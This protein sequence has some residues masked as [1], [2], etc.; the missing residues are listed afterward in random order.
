[1]CVVGR[2]ETTAERWQGRADV[3]ELECQ[4]GIVMIGRADCRFIYVEDVAEDPD[5][6][7][8]A[9]IALGDVLTVRKGRFDCGVRG[10]PLPCKKCFD[11]R[12]RIRYRRRAKPG[13]PM[14]ILK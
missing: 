7:R 10:I 2:G 13:H 5:P 8:A 3:E 11:L 14:C 6:T 1:M 9:H 4:I 12:K